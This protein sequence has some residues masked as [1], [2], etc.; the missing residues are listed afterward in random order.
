MK[1][2]TK[3]TVAAIFILTLVVLLGFV[4]PIYFLH[5][6]ERAYIKSTKTTMDRLA[7][8]ADQK[9]N[10]DGEYIKVS[11]NEKDAWG[12]PLVINY[13]EGYRRRF[14]SVV[15]VQTLQVQ[16]AGPDK[17]LNTADDIYDRERWSAA[18]GASIEAAAETAGRGFLRN[19]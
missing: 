3:E 16:S 15:Y 17:E 9:V 4:L 8:V 18:I 6:S 7:D 13:N 10:L 11:H 5:F 14:G 2:D 1:D 19:R 12:T